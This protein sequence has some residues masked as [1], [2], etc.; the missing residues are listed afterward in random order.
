MSLSSFKATDDSINQLLLKSGIIAKM[1][2]RLQRQ[3]TTISSPDIYGITTWVGNSTSAP[4]GYDLFALIALALSESGNL[5]FI[6][7]RI[8]SGGR[9]SACGLF[10]I[11]EMSRTSVLKKSN[12]HDAGDFL[13]YTCPTVNWF[14]A[15]KLMKTYSSLSLGK[16][17]PDSIL[18]RMFFWF[19]GN[20]NGISEMTNEGT[21]LSLL[22]LST[23]MSSFLTELAA[24]QN[25]R[26]AQMTLRQYLALVFDKITKAIAIINRLDTDIIPTWSNGMLDKQISNS[27]NKFFIDKTRERILSNRSFFSNSV[28]RYCSS[29]IFKKKVSNLERTKMEFKMKVNSKFGLKNSNIDFENAV[30]D[31]ITKNVTPWDDISTDNWITKQYDQLIKYIL[32]SDVG[33][34]NRALGMIQNKEFYSTVISK[35]RKHKPGVVMYMIATRGFAYFT[36]MILNGIKINT[37]AVYEPAKFVTAACSLE[38]I[39]VYESMLNDLSSELTQKPISLGLTAA[40]KTAAIKETNT[41]SNTV[42]HGKELQADIDALMRDL[43]LPDK[44]LH[45]GTESGL[46][47]PKRT[48]VQRS[49]PPHTSRAQNKTPEHHEKQV[50]MIRS[51]YVPGTFGKRKPQN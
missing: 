30:L 2:I 6:P 12:D 7:P 35:I 1:I 48:A 32:P 22:N 46:P 20:L 51:A 28:E 47:Q 21:N 31:E 14:V 23:P 40:T 33:I 15:T 50:N 27:N 25:S 18:L 16:M 5:V 3:S 24:K 17:Y 42:L 11:I 34:S 38:D 26:V 45:T 9:N 10:G 8:D 29:L 13:M 41:T 36:N 43:S 37:T 44:Q 39:A 4:N 19:I 49:T